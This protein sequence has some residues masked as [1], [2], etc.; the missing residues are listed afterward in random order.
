MNYKNIIANCL[1]RIWSIL[2]ILLLTP[3]YIEKLGFESYGLIGFFA[4]IQSIATIL[5]LG[6]PLAINKAVAR[7]TAKEI[8]TEEIS[9]L[10]KIFEMF[11]AGAALILCLLAI[12][13]SYLLAENW[14]VFSSLTNQKVFVVLICIFVLVAFRFP[15]GLYLGV[16]AGLQKQVQMNGLN[17]LFAT[18]RL[19]S[20]G[21]LIAFWLPDILSF[22]AI[23]IFFSL[24]ELLVIRKIAWN[25]HPEFRNDM[26]VSW[27]SIKEHVSFAI[28]VGVIT[29]LGIVLLQLDKLLTSGF[30]SLEE[31]GHYSLIGVIGLGLMTIGYPVAAASFPNFVKLIA[32][33]KKE[34]L[35]REYFL[36]FRFVILMVLPI[37][38]SLAVFSQSI[39]E[40]Y[41]Q[42]ES[43]GRAVYN[44]F[45][46]FVIASFFGSLRPISFGL[47]LAYNQ[48][49][50]VINYYLYLL[51]SYSLILFLLIDS[52]SIVGAALGFL[53]MQL[54]SVVVFFVIAIKTLDNNKVPYTLFRIFLVPIG[55]CCLAAYVLAEM[56]SFRVA[57]FHVI[58]SVLVVYF[59]TLMVLAL[60]LYSRTE[61]I[62]GTSFLL[63]LR[64]NSRYNKEKKY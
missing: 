52:M 16:L 39:L 59:P 15:I 58:T 30:L 64:R 53:L 60:A 31:F 63:N 46:L 12:P 61:I 42:S 17:I 45:F 33:N 25:S 29:I 62:T 1:G 2:L 18:L 44:A 19:G 21:L 22:F 56:L 41:M 20:A 48:Q 10:L 3:L 14:F 51:P 38:V 54:V 55:L 37:T 13:L 11:F 24:I 43:L 34:E 9:S 27:N 47:I 8:D 6:V 5:E 36:Y 28:N 23:Q 40:F 32:E 57:S 4:V 49:K 7:F 50:K 35:K 26:I